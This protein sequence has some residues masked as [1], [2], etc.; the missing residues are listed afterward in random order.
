MDEACQCGK[1]CLSDVALIN[2]IAI[3]KGRVSERDSWKLEPASSVVCFTVDFGLII[4]YTLCRKVESVETNRHYVRVKQVL[5]YE[6]CA[7]K[8]CLRALTASPITFI[9]GIPGMRAR[10]SEW[11]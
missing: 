11:H 3:S 2:V 8:T 7:L 4:L 5:C 10:G 6:I 9:K 1:A